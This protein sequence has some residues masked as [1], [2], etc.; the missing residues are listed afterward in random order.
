[1]ITQKSL[2]IKFLLAVFGFIAIFSAFVTYRVWTSSNA[3]L[4]EL[5]DEQA[6]L[7]LEFDLAIRAYVAEDVRPDALAA[8]TAGF[9]GAQIEHLVNEAGLLAVKETLTQQL[10]TDAARVR[11]DH[12]LRAI[13]AAR[14]PAPRVSHRPG[15]RRCREAR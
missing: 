14:S 10:P 5:L 6:G 1:M 7:A 15:Y 11:P 8:R 9:T 4:T 2:G 13:A 12:F 3:H